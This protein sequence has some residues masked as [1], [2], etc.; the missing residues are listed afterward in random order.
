MLYDLSRKKAADRLGVSIRTVDRYLKKNI[1]SR[2]VVDGSVYLSSLEIARYKE[3]SSV[4]VDSTGAP[5]V[6]TSRHALSGQILSTGQV[7]KGAGA[8]KIATSRNFSKN[9]FLTIQSE[10]ESLKKELNSIKSDYS[11]M[12]TQI[13]T[14]QKEAQ[15]VKQ[16]LKNKILFYFLLFLLSLQPV[17]LF[18]YFSS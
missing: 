5:P 3:K 2:Q 9:D 1:L 4:D 16:Q 12:I 6:H 11:N 13:F 8:G 15:I 10:L 17:W 7:D 14:K 18:L